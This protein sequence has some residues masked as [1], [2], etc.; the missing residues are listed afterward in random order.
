MIRRT[1]ELSSINSPKI[2]KEIDFKTALSI[3]V[4]DCEIRNLR[5]QTIQLQK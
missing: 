5:R 2:V 4:D 1:N 3:F